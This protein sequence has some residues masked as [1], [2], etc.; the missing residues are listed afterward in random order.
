M[1]LSITNNVS[2]CLLN[3]GHAVTVNE[4]LPLLSSVKIIKHDQICHYI[5]IKIKSVMLTEGCGR[6]ET[7][8]TC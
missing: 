3:Q 7:S 4:P 2:H 8:K 6:I 5:M 1:G